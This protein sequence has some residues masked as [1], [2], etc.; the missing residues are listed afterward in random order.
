MPEVSV[1]FFKTLRRIQIQ[2]FHLAQ[3]LLAGAYKSAFK[4]KGMEFEDVREYLPG[5]EIRSI[6]WN[7]TARMGHP[8]VKNFR[9][10][11]ELSVMLVADIS[12]SSRYGSGEYLKSDLIAEIGAVIA[13]SAIKNN[14]KIGLILFSDIVEKYIPPRKGIRHVLRIIRE[15]L[16]FQPTKAGTNM[17]KALSYL[18]KVQ[19]RSGV[20]FLI[21]DFLT[22]GYEHELALTARRHDLISIIVT[23]PTEVAFPKMGLVDLVDFES[24]ERKVV[25]S[26]N[27]TIQEQFKFRTEERLRSFRKLMNKLGVGF[28]DIR[29]NKPFLPEIRKFFKLRGRNR[30]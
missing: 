29:T 17:A 30:R 23:D 26:S 16:A 11:R 1:D 27:K 8:Y 13:F 2:T 19:F 12:S 5:D 7:V 3:D 14:D 25:D 6:D 10:E 9:E 4:G 21:S 20:C 22:N 18:G 24:G 15:L 28:I